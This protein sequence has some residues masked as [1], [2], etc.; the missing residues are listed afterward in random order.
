MRKAFY[1]LALLLGYTYL[2]AQEHTVEQPA[3]DVRN[4]NSLEIQKIVLSDTA[5]VFYIDAYYRPKN[6]IRI[7]QATVLETGGKSYPIRS[8]VGIELDK[9]FWM[10]E[11]GTASF[12]LVFAPLPK[13]TK[14]VDFVEGH[15]DGAF[16]IWGI[17]LDG[18]P[19]HSPLAGKKNPKETVILEKPELKTGIGT[20]TGKLIG[21]PAD[22]NLTLDAWVFNIL[23]GGAD[24]YKV[25][26]QADGSFKLEVP[27]LHISTVGLMSNVFHTDLYLKPSETSSVEVN[28]PEIS[29]QS[30]KIHDKSP[31]LGEKFYFSGTL[32]AL[33]NEISNAPEVRI[34]LYPE[35]EEE[36]MQQ[37]KEISTMTVEQ[38]K[39]NWTERYQKA[40]DK[41]NQQEGLSDALRQLK[42]LSLKHSLAENIMNPSIIEY[43]Y[44]QVN[45]IPRDSVLTDYVKPIPTKS[46]FSF[47]PELISND[48]YFL[49][50]GSFAYLMR[51]LQYANFTGKELKLGK[52]EPLPDNTA[53]IA[54]VMGTNEGV[55][56]E[57]LAGQRIASS[58]QEFKPLSEVELA[59]ADKLDPA[60]KATLIDMN[61]T[62]KQTIEE[63]KKKSGYTVNRINTADIPSEELFNAITTPYRGKVVFVD[64]WATWCGPC[65]MAM[66]EAE[67]IKETFA[68]KDVV[69]LYLAGENSP[70]GAWNQM[71]PDIKGEHYR[72]TQAQW[73][74]LG[75]K[76]GIQ[77]VPSYMIIA[78]DGTPV[79]FQVGFMGG[80]KM[81]EMLNKELAK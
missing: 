16:R 74:F 4:T 75:K 42:A 73:D 19:T 49:Y 59:K 41:L 51:N 15:D 47:L 1:L 55:L 67:P 63:N 45:K 80:E 23:K 29:R 56:F 13:E 65:K 34:S 64:F 7:A 39:A 2:Q 71:I 26:V 53:D 11:S 43:S 79:H 78:K 35:S 40:L 52:D 50:D 36:Y 61:N 28:L 66:K 30:S 60:I 10:P 5:T 70:I 27:L 46:Y 48:S 58:I 9:E 33:N 32:A 76:F 6:W 17:H 3:F 31:S 69:F 21:Y 72:V 20:L 77:G 37:L 12:Q 68:G 81:K 8:G 22:M 54:E 24:E 44:R 25:P 18:T 14:T 38:F 57:L 62:L